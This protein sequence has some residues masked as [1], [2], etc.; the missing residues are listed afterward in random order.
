MVKKVFLIF[1]M[2]AVM[3]GSLFSADLRYINLNAIKDMNAFSDELN[4]ALLNQNAMRWWV[5]DDA[6]NN[7][8][9]KSDVASVLRDLYVKLSEHADP[10][11]Q[12]YLLLKAV[13]SDFLYNFDEPGFF[14]VTKANYLAIETLP[15]RDYRYKWFLGTFLGNACKGPEA[16]DCFRYILDQIPENALVPDFFWDYGN[17]LYQAM[18]PSSAKHA[19]DTYALYSGY[20]IA[21]NQMYRNVCNLLPEY[22]MDDVENIVS[23]YIFQPH[24]RDGRQG[25]LSKL[26][27]IW[28]SPDE[29]WTVNQSGLTVVKHT[30]VY[31]SAPITKNGRNITYSVLLIDELAPSYPECSAA[32]TLES[33]RQGYTTVTEVNLFPDKPAIRVYELKEPSRYTECGGAH[34]YA[35]FV[36]S[37]YEPDA[38]RIF[39]KP[40]DINASGTKGD[41]GVTYYRVMPMYTRFKGTTAHFILL[42][43]CEAIWEESSSAFLEFLK[44]CEFF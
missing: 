25:K 8:T 33:V 19:F 16:V 31:S 17:V 3:G 21:N 12:E 11:N 37:G 23:D 10:E 28:Y 32:D 7:P 5:S 24:N 41:G 1:V 18:M 13:I 26:Y 6:W 44:T 36:E 34:G 43:S 4:Y 30:E 27:G 40:F 14:E 2:L 38:E 9:P 42:D 29:E 39:E 22:D 20:D 15:E 35:V